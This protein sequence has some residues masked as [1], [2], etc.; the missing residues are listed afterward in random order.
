MYQPSGATAKFPQ[1]K[2]ARKKLALPVQ[3]TAASCACSPIENS[4]ACGK[5]WDRKQRLTEQ[6]SR[7]LGTQRAVG[8]RCSLWEDPSPSYD[9]C[10][11]VTCSSTPISG[12]KVPEKHVCGTGG[13]LSTLRVG[14]TASNGREGVPAKGCQHWFG[15][16]SRS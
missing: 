9:T 3:V 2:D 10:G 14:R 12:R 1:P 6:R 5:Q 13:H 8:S 16:R 7:Q 4:S 15:F 11:N